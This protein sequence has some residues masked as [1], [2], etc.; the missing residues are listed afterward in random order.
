MIRQRTLARSLTCT[1]R[2]LH[3]GAAVRM[4]LQPAEP[5]T[6]IRFC[7]TDLPARPLIVA[8]PDRVVETK[9]CTV[10]GD[11]NG[12]RVATVEHLMSALRAAGIDNA[13]IGLDGPEVPRSDGSAKEFFEAIQT[14]G[15]VEQ[16]P[17]RS[18]R[19]LRAP[20]WVREGNRELVALPAEGFSVSLMT[21]NDHGHPALTDRLVEYALDPD[22]YGR[23]IAPSRTIGFV[24]EVQALLAAGLAAGFDIDVQ[25]L[26][27]RE[28]LIGAD[29]DAVVLVGRERVL[30]PLRFPDEIARH[31]VLDLIGD[32]GLCG[33]LNAHIIGIRSSHRLNALLAKGIAAQTA[34]VRT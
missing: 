33:P 13:W 14:A 1:G 31:K 21:T 4:E 5:N 11:D 22:T 26:I 2:G 15:S 34:E 32:I 28:E 7:R 30:T 8:H 19:T 16:A 25:A 27:E 17:E 20:V 29:V 18:V 10:L 6:G 24:S 12:A 23:E 9:R 3:S